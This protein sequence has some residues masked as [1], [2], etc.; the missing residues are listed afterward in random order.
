MAAVGAAT[1]TSPS[2]TTTISIGIRISMVATGTTST[3]GIA[4][5]AH[6]N[7]LREDVVTV[8]GS[9]IRSI[10]AGP[11][12]GIAARQIA[13]AGRLVEIRWRT[14]RPVRG[15]RSGARAVTWAPTAEAL[16]ELAVSVERAGLEEWAG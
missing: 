9:I 3:V 8:T 10:G 5:I 2:T 7:C 13:S 11:L 4:A 16:A 15:T 14:G 1:T 12:M 6:R